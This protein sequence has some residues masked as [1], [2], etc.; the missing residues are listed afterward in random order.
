MQLPPPV[1]RAPDIGVAWAIPEGMLI[2]P[3]F[4]PR[5]K[6]FRL[7]M[8]REESIV[9]GRCRDVPDIEIDPAKNVWKDGEYYTPNWMIERFLPQTEVEHLELAEIGRAHV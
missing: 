8:F 5:P 1:S 7:G 2:P 3:D 4:K 9:V 6:T